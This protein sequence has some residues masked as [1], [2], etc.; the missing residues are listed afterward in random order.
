MT[1]LRIESTPFGPALQQPWAAVRDALGL[2][3]PDDPPPPEGTPCLLAFDGENPVARLAFGA[4]EGFSGA[5]G[6]TGFVGW[7]EAVSGEAGAAILRAAKEE[8]FGRGAARVVGPLNGSTWA[9]YRIALPVEGDLAASPPFLTEPQNP[10]GY[11]EHF[12]AAGFR[13]HLEYESR[14]VRTPG[15]EG[16]EPGPVPLPDGGAV[17]I[18]TLDLARYDEELRAIFEVSVEAFPANPFYTEIPFAAFAAMYERMRPLLDPELVWLAWSPEGRLLGYVF[19]FADALG[20]GTPPRI[21]LKTLATSPAARRLGLGRALTRRI[22]R[23]AAGRG[24][25][26]IH[27]L[28]QKTN[29]SVHI[30]RGSES[31]PLRRYLLFAAEPG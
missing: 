8:L 4:R 23:V 9:R 21:V 25:E 2:R 31:E 6:V 24:A 12:A 1:T 16:E 20:G 7:Y 30:S 3:T 13:P 11:A 17:E 22:H 15:D 5:P 19:A 26:V 29:A 10:A 28:M 27:A 14:L 18:R